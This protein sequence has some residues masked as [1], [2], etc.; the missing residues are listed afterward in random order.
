[1]LII[2]RFMISS[3]KEV[4]IIKSENQVKTLIENITMN[5]SL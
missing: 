4:F 5:P 1:M 2:L 3:V